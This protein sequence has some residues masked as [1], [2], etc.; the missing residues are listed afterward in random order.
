MDRYEID[1]LIGKLTQKG[2]KF[3]EQTHLIEWFIFIFS[4]F[5]GKGS[6]GQ[7]V[8]AFDHEEQCHVAIKIIKN[9][10][11]FLNQAQ[12]EV[13]LL[14]MMNRADVENKYYIGKFIEQT[15]QIVSH[16]PTSLSFIKHLNVRLIINI[17]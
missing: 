1:S 13:K 10:K 14:E 6:F 3:F 8:K 7:V 16:R 9:K 5:L 11:P 2:H 12:I 17:I 4:P 15:K